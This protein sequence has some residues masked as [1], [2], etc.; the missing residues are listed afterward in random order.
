[1]KLEANCKINLGLDV[2]RRREDGYHDLQTVMFPVREL[3]DTV[4]V[5]RTAAAGVEFVQTGL[6]V[7]CP[8]EKNICVRAFRMMQRRFGVDGVRIALDKRTPFGAGLGGGSA[9]GTAVVLAVN[10]LFGLGLPEC[11]L[12]ECA[13]ELGS[14]TAFFVRNRPQMCEGRGEIMTPFDVDLEGLWLVVAKPA[15]GVSTAEAYAGIAPAVPAVPLAE[16]LRLPVRQWQGAVKNDFEMSVFASHPSVRAV[17]DAL[18][19][20]GAVYA[21]MSGSGS[22]CF[23]LF[24]DRA[25]AAAW[26]PPTDVVFVHREKIARS[27]I[28]MQ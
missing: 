18:L 28:A 19:A 10:E 3:F 23:G 16:R 6:V 13:A 17:R 5:E 8:A 1:M 24:A 14:D 2:L 15:E 27:S 22:A 26:R 21:S 11:Q 20:Q 12:V 25:S 4:E 9:D 7:D